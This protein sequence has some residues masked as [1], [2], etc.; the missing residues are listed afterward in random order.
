MH[1]SAFVD[2]LDPSTV[3]LTV[4]NVD[5]PGREHVTGMF[6]DLF[7]RQPVDVT[8][9]ASDV[10]DENLVVLRR[11]GERVAES[12]L[13]AVGDAVLFVNS[14]IYITGSREL[15]GV[16][17][18]DVLEA[19]TDVPFHAEGYPSKRKEKL[20]LIEISRHVEARAYR[21]GAGEL[22]S[23][24][25]RLSRIDDEQGT[26]DAYDAI[27]ASDLDAHVYGLDDS[28][29]DQPGLSAHSGSEELG[30]VW[31]VVYV[32]PEGVDAR[33]AALVCVEAGP[34]EWRGFWTFDADRVRAVR[35]YVADAYQA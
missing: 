32:P 1:L 10:V 33:H 18:P 12:E 28:T 21:A 17:T 13:D 29:P 15:E 2:D 31:F 35:D 19:L 3:T 6:D 26:Y 8:R 4:V 9:A 27:G 7:D 34:G 24:F 20:L 22:H 16:Q 14:D 23:G 11:N 25:Q 30:E 5:G